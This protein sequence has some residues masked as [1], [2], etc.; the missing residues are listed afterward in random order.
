MDTSE[1]NNDKM[2]RFIRYPKG[3]T[4]CVCGLICR[5]Y[6]LVMTFEFQKDRTGK[7]TMKITRTPLMGEGLIPLDTI[8]GSSEELCD[9]IVSSEERYVDIYVFFDMLKAQIHYNTF[10]C[11]KD[12]LHDV[13]QTNSVIDV[14]DNDIYLDVD[15]LDGGR[16]VRCRNFFFDRE[17]LVRDLAFLHDCVGREIYFNEYE[18]NAASRS[19]ARQLDAYLTRIDQNGLYAGQ[20]AGRGTVYFDGEFA[21][22]AD[23]RQPVK[24]NLE[25][26]CGV[27][28]NIRKEILSNKEQMDSLDRNNTRDMND[29][30]KKD[31]E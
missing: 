16:K 18:K 30:W 28:Q 1:K 10:T 2:I 25:E 31:D 8:T 3:R 9:L 26:F 23:G 7:P 27:A 5:I 22:T 29:G 14:S 12:S 13:M 21:F 17:T 6:G 19:L 11:M 15:V 24:M 4:A 20:I